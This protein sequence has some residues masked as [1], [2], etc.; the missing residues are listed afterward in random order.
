MRPARSLCWSICQIN[1]HKRGIFQEARRFT[2]NAF[3]SERRSYRPKTSAVAMGLRR[4]WTPCATPEL[5]LSPHPQSAQVANCL[6]LSGGVAGCD[7]VLCPDRGRLRE[8]IRL[9]E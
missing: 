7:A 3:R 2:A 4:F 1:A 8:E 9:V 6:E 5:V